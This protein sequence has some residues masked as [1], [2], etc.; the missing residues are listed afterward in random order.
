MRST[1]I[2]FACETNA[3]TRRN[4]NAPHPPP[5]SSRSSRSTARFTD[6]FQPGHG[7]FPTWFSGTPSAGVGLQCKRTRKTQHST[8]NVLAHYWY[9]TSLILVNYY[10]V[11][12]YFSQHTRI[13]LLYY[14]QMQAWL[15]TYG[16]CPKA[17]RS[18]QLT[19]KVRT[20]RNLFQQTRC[21]Y[22]Q[23]W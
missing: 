14:C 23:L 8:C 13:L 3:Q 12:S 2:K 4:P 15:G 21:T 9:I 22:V 18:K 17:A 6:W 19:T 20:C 5:E 7:P 11:T 10:Y 1:S 16:G